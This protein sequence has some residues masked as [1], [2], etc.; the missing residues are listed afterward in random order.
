MAASTSALLPI[1]LNSAGQQADLSVPPDVAL[2]ELVPAMVQA[3]GPLDAANASQGYAVL[4]GAGH[5][6]Q[7]SLSLKDQGVKPGT[8]L[9]LEAKGSGIGDQRYDDLVEAVGATV[10]EEQNPWERSHSI[11]LSAHAS[12]V[13]ILVAALLLV[14][15]SSFT[16]LTWAVAGAGAVLTALAAAVVAR[17]GSPVGGVSLAH[18]APVLLGAAAFSSAAEEWYRLPLF[19]AGVAITAGSLVVLALPAAQRSSV[20]APLTTGPALLACGAL[21]TF[22]QIPQDRAAALVLT[23]L[24]VIQLAAPWM[25]VA[26]LPVEVGTAK[27]RTPIDPSLVADRVASGHQL[28]LSLKV[29]AALASAPL[30]LLLMD[31][32]QALALV[33][34]AGVALMLSTRSLRSHAE[35]L[36]GVLN[37]MVL[38]VVAAVG[39][40]TSAPTTLP[41][42]LAGTIAV[43][44]LLLAANVVSPKLRPNVTRLADAAGVLALLALLPLAALVWG[45]L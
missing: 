25:A 26:Q 22:A 16:L 14:T 32:M 5:E 45:V 30:S 6:L 11:Q 43:A 19:L 9:T 1:T 28:V 7:Q 23:A 24:V 34:C 4:S 40:T 42:V 39:T 33:A 31:S 37:G 17:S 35:V 3:L 12:A 44:V 10:A 36:V 13:L 18:T 8:V 27:D 21:T 15:G 29:G 38:T 41:W 20:A 2:A